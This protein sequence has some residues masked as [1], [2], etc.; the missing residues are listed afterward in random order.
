MNISLWYPKNMST[1]KILAISFGTLA[2]LVLV[3]FIGTRII[4]NQQQSLVDTSVQVEQ[5]SSKRYE[6][7]VVSISAEQDLLHILENEQGLTVIRVLPEMRPEIAGLN[8]GDRVVLFGVSDD[9]QNPEL[10]RLEQVLSIEAGEELTP[11]ENVRLNS[12]FR[13]LRM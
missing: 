7:V 6:G 3:V 11:E 8:E 13:G 10:V 12:E 5:E 1:K 9:V 2:L 4:D